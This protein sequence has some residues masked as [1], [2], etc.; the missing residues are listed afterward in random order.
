MLEDH[1]EQLARQTEEARLLSKDL[2][3]VETTRIYS[4]E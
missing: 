1:V 3:I 2:G 4:E